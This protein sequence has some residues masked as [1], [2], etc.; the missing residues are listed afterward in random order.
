MEGPAGFAFVRGGYGH[1]AAVVADGFAHVAQPAFGFIAL[2]DFVE[3]AVGGYP[4]FGQI[5]PNARQ[6]RR[7]VA[8]HLAVALQHAVNGRRNFGNGREG[9]EPGRQHGRILLVGEHKAV[10]V[11]I[12][13][14]LC[15]DR[16]ELFG[17]EHRILNAQQGKGVVHLR[18]SHGRKVVAALHELQQFV[19]LQ[20]RRLYLALNGVGLHGQQG[21]AAFAR[22]SVLGN[23]PLEQVKVE[24]LSG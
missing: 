3:N 12:G 22:C 7:S 18:H 16:H 21:F 24:R 9:L 4:F 5:L 15:L 17:V 13:F 11:G 10:A 2:E 20:E 1:D 14:R 23:I 6:L 19:R 8:L